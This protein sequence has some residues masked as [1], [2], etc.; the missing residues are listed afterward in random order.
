MPDPSPIV[1][2]SPRQLLEVLGGCLRLGGDG[3]LIVEDEAALRASGAATLAWTATF[4]SDQ[5]TVEAAR[6]LVWEASQALGA[7]STS[8][9]GLYRARG[10]GEVAGFTVPA[11]NLRTQVFDMAAAIFRAARARDVG[12]VILEL[13]RS[14]QE[15]TFQ[16]PPEFITNVLAGA[17]HA[18]WDQPVF[19]QGDHYQFNAAKYKADPE[20]VTEGLRRLIREALASGYGN[21]DIDSSTLVDLGRPTVEEQQRTNFERAAELTALIRE[22]EPDALTISVGGEIGEVGKENSTEAELEAYLAGYRTELDR[23]AGSDGPGVSKVSVQTGTSHGGIPLPDGSVA[24]V[25]LDFGVLERLGAV[26]RRHGLAGAV[27]HGASTL[28]DELFHRFPKVET[29]EIHLAT[30]FQNALYEHPAF[31]ADLYAEITAWCD[32]HCAAERTEGQ[33]ETQFIYKTRKKAFGPF[34]RTLWDLPERAVILAAQEAKI[35][36]LMEQLAVG[37]TA[38]LVARHVEV[39]ERHRPVP[40]ALS[41]AT[42]G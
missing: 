28:P 11:V 7:R 40:A 38:E 26:A 3:G 29:A 15:Y 30:G 24:P 6:W 9:E 10:R 2:T 21:I 35:G 27:Q 14:E 13:A 1:A 34:K 12:P 39:P 20:A 16:R 31:P 33:D 8:I 17:L 18:A 22:L 5:A 19:V 37:G 4:S 25:K 42:V 32:E 41:A 36:F 23:R